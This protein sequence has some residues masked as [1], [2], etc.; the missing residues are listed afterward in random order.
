MQRVSRA[1][2]VL[3]MLLGCT[4]CYTSATPLPIVIGHVSDKTR[5]DKAGDQAELGI[6]LALHEA[7]KDGALTELFT[8]RKIEVHH[9]DARGDLDKFESQAVR[10]DSV[11]RCLALFGG[12]SPAET[13]ALNH[14]KLPLLTFHG[15]PVSGAN[16]QVIYLGM[17]P[18]R[19]GVVLAKTVA[20]DEKASRIVVLMDERRAESTAFSESFQKTLEEAR[21]QTKGVPPV[22][23]A[24][25]FGKDAKW[26]DLVERIGTHDP[27]AVVFAGNVQDFNSWHKVYR[28]ELFRNQPTQIVYAGADGDHR[29]FDLEGDE[30]TAVLL[31]TA[32]YADPGAEKITAFMKAY[33]EAFKTEADVHAALA[34]DGFRIL[35]EAIKRTPTQ[36]TPERVREELLQTKDLAGLTGPLTIT[37]EREVQRMLFVMRWQNGVL[38]MQKTFAP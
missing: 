13:A 36:L 38:T 15:Q 29:L 17:S 19:Q 32:F 30:K 1:I 14:A 11:N 26:S 37:S 18:E 31:A 22:I 2:I 25:R 23:L 28:R 34:Y 27:D 8:G 16:N 10:L 4:G 6:R 21:K 24:L 5:L 12:L 33:R 7:N 20:E 9:T 35:I 3:T